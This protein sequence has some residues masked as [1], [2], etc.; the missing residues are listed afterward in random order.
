MAFVQLGY[1]GER[2]VKLLER[3]TRGWRASPAVQAHLAWRGA[4]PAAQRGP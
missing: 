3:Y 2:V 1:A 4:Q